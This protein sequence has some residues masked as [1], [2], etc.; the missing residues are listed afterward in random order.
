MTDRYKTLSPSVSGPAASGFAVTPSDT[1]DLP[2]TTRALYVGIAGDL[3]V[4]M[5]NGET[6]TLRNVAQGAVLPLRT[7]RILQ[8]GTSASAIVGL[9]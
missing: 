9:V 3:A 4:K 8:T 1:L 5:A 7:T 6:L 2:E